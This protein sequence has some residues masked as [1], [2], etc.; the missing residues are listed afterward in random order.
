MDNSVVLMPL[1]KAMET[2]P[3][4]CLWIKPTFTKISSL[5]M[6]RTPL[7]PN[8][9]LSGAFSGVCTTKPVKTRLLGKQT[10]ILPQTIGF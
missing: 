10:I 3:Y 1:F 6:W 2:Y 5:S 4:L 7:S 9:N 8:L